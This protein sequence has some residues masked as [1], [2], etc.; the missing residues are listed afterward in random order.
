[1]RICYREDL[2]FLMFAFEV[3]RAVNQSR[4]LELMSVSVLTVRECFCKMHML[5]ASNFN[6]GRGFAAEFMKMVIYKIR[7]EFYFVHMAA[8]VLDRFAGHR[9][10]TVIVAVSALI[11]CCGASHDLMHMLLFLTATCV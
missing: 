2:S 7:A 11:R 4:Y 5:S 6:G 1:M 3:K 8:A 9:A 10:K